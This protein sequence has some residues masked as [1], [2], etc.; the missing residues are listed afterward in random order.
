M[1]NTDKTDKQSALQKLYKD[2][3]SIYTLIEIEQEAL[4]LCRENEKDCSH[5][6]TLTDIILDK[7]R[8]TLKNLETISK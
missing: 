8:T 1:K 6:I 7:F 3:P 5:I 4:D 2:L